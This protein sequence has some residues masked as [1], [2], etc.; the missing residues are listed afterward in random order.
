MINLLNRSNTTGYQV[1]WQR[2]TTAETRQYVHECKDIAD[3]IL[4][5]AALYNSYAKDDTV[6]LS[7]VTLSL[8]IV[9]TATPG[10]VV[11]ISKDN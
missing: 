10:Y 9:F 3:A 4:F 7:E 2:S 1:T 11:T 5:I 6:T 8:K